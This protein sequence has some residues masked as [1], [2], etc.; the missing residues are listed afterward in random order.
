MIV[1][2]AFE[3][4]IDG[5]MKRFVIGDIISD[6]QAGIINAVEKGLVKSESE[7]KA[8]KKGTENAKTGRS[9]I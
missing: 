8:F 6:E 7:T 2:K 5:E 1:V 9:K 3:T 4:E